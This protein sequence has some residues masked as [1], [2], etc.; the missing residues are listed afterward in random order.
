MIIIVLT[1]SHQQHSE[2][3]LSSSDSS[4]ANDV[5]M[6][7]QGRQEFLLDDEKSSSVKYQSCTECTDEN[8]D[9]EHTY[10]HDSKKKEISEIKHKHKKEI[11][12]NEHKNILLKKDQRSRHEREL[13][14]AKHGM[15][16]LQVEQ[17]K[18]A[19]KKRH[20]IE[21]RK[22]V[23]SEET[24]LSARPTKLGGESSN[25]MQTSLKISTESHQF[26]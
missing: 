22:I 6:S 23:N 5:D 8:P 17:E 12:E 16:L 1:Y 10:E 3:D 25:N 4:S 18:E 7:N 24:S 9:V 2:E 20:T 21:L 14:E 13:L 26:S 11:L 19:M 15:K